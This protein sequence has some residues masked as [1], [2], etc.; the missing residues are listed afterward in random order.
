MRR[1]NTTEEDLDDLNKL[2]LEE[3]L[4]SKIQFKWLVLQ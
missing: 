3:F 2:G 1:N 4:D